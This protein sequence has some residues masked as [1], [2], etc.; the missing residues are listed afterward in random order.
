[1]PT[2]FYQGYNVHGS[3]GVWNVHDFPLEHASDIHEGVSIYHMPTPGAAGTILYSDGTYWQIGDHGNI[4]GLSDDDHT[5]YL[6]ANGTRA[7]TA[8]WDA[9]GYKITALQFESDVVTGTAPLIVASTTLVTNLNADLLDGQHGAYYLTG[10]NI[11]GFTAGS[12]IFAGVGGVLA[13]DNASFFWDDT[14]NRLG[15]GTAIPAELLSLQASGNAVRFQAD[16][17]YTSA[18]SASQFKFQKARGTSASPLTVVDGDTLANLRWFGYDGAA[19]RE[20][21]SIFAVVDGAVSSGIVP[22]EIYFQTANSSGVLTTRLYI[23]ASGKIG[24]NQTAPGRT[25]SITGDF[26]QIYNSSAEAGI[27]FGETV[28]SGLIDRGFSIYYDAPDNKMYID[29][30]NASTALG[31]TIMTFDRANYR[32]GVG[33]TT[34]LLA[35]LHI[36]QESTTG[37]MP[38]LLLDQ[39]DVS[40]EFIRFIGTSAN[41]V[42]TQSIVDAADVATA[43]VVGYLEVYVQD[44]GNQLTDQS[45][46]IPI[47]T[48]A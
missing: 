14:N 40:E 19:F 20:A 47:Y 38:V 2:T 7:L 10:S 12:V 36:D 37:A 30:H 15:L 31:S 35:K 16:T 24:I 23:D 42:L 32:V 34:S 27:A 17:Y 33:P 13:Q 18:S 44:D 48:L 1:M 8:N 26:V 3:Q 22:G 29:Y 5:I 41:G 43:T 45:Y 6:L 9:G 11:G 4:G 39:S 28:S 46:Y 25:L 21:A